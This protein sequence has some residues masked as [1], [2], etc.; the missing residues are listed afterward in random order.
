[1]RRVAVCLLLVLA[2]C[3]EDGTIE[4][5]PAGSGGSAGVAA[6]GGNGGCS[7]S[8]QC[9]GAQPFCEISTGSCVGCL[10]SGHCGANRVCDPGTFECRNECT[11]D[12]N[13]ELLS[14]PRCDTSQGV[15][16]QCLGDA[17]CTVGDHRHCLVS[18]GRCVECRTDGD[19]GDA[20]KP[21]CPASIRD[22][23]PCLVNAHCA[24]GTHCNKDFEC[25]EGSR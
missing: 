7:T 23:R 12:T 2:A 14:E 25:E 18:T 19:C 1:M 11:N 9:S 3:G 24:P 20:E 17:D 15:C 5:S 10:V 13:C 8:A 16:V 6:T 4:L 21:Y 22:C